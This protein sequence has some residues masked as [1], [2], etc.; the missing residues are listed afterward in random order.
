M[1]G[2]LSARLKRIRSQAGLRQEH[3]PRIPLSDSGI[4]NWEKIDPLVYRR[5]IDIAL[6]QR[7]QNSISSQLSM[8][9]RNSDAVFCTERS[10]KLEQLLFFDLETSGLSSGAGTVAFLAAFGR[11]RHTDNLN[12][13]LSV[14]QFLLLDYPG[15]AVFLEQIQMQLS[16]IESDPVVVSYNGKSFDIPLLRSRLVMNGLQPFAVKH[17]DLL[18]PARLL[19]KTILP[20]CSL[21]EIEKSV[22]DFDRGLDL[23]GSQAPEAWFAF[24]KNGTWDALDKICEHNAHDLHGLALLFDRINRTSNKPL[25]AHKHDKLDT[26]A[27]FLR[28]FYYLKRQGRTDHALISA[29]YNTG[30]LNTLYHASRQYVREG[31]YEEAKTL[32]FRIVNDTGAAVKR[33]CTAYRLLSIIEEWKVKNYAAALDYA[34][35]ARDLYDH[36]SVPSLDHDKRINRLKEKTGQA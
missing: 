31:C 23:P 34:Q 3:P 16:D 25:Y 19:W 7:I 9:F 32:L 22:L 14:T 26:D 36:D 2:N 20:S 28:Y 8:F 18:H 33:V 21:T 12:T 11:Y 6:G 4:K 13:A 1:G 27:L 10:I 15:E 5:T 24:L 29:A 35:K 17:L 30:A